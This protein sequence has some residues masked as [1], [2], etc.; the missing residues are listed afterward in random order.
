MGNRAV[1]TFDT[2]EKSPCIYLHWNG[3]RASVEAFLQA[4]QYLGAVHPGN[5]AQRR[6]AVLDW[7][8]TTVAQHFFGCDVGM[9]VYRE[10]YGR[11]DRDNWD[12]GVYV[13]G[14]DMRIARRLFKQRADEF[15]PTKTREI[16]EHLV[17]R[18][19]IFNN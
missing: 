11:T 8:A 7:M 16:F 4:A 17:V 3:G 9:T 5:D 13:I 12:N 18:A 14:P 6:L 15:D 1:I 10:E 2:G 19:P